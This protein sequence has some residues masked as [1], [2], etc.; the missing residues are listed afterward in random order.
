[1]IHGCVQPLIPVWASL[2]YAVHR[3][4][5]VGI[6]GDVGVQEGTGGSAAAVLELG[7][8]KKSVRVTAWWR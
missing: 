5:H 4:L 6:C 1:V 8:R 7:L 2:G 3:L